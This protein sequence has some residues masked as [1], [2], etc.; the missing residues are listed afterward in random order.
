[1]ELKDLQGNDID[2][3]VRNYR[4]SLGEQYDAGVATLN[5]QR[6]NDFAGIM[7]GSNK[8]GM[9]Y[10]N[11]PERSKMQYDTQTYLPGFIKLRQNYQSGIDKLRA[12]VV[13]LFNQSKSINEAIADLNEIK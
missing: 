2:Q 8:A 3:F 6:A 10:S 1:M 7:A 9:L 12:N 11:F 5:Q 4:K 13:D